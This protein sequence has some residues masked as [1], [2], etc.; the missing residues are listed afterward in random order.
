MLHNNKFWHAYTYLQSTSSPS[1][2]TQ[3][4]RR[5]NAYSKPTQQNRLKVNEDDA[6]HHFS[7]IK[8]DIE[9]YDYELASYIASVLIYTHLSHRHHR[10]HQAIH[11]CLL[12][13]DDMIIKTPLQSIFYV[14]MLVILIY[15]I[16]SAQSPRQTHS[17]HISHH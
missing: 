1:S 8:V 6:H 16:R 2:S 13:I 15:F 3:M 14:C 10:H 11:V 12:S 4:L 7:F 17:S 5:D 9:I